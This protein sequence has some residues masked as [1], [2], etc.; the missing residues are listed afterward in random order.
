MNILKF[1]RNYYG[2]RPNE[3]GRLMLFFLTLFANSVF[4]NST[5]IVGSTLFLSHPDIKGKVQFVL[6][7]FLLPVLYLQ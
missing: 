5:N 2:I 1:A 3:F 4:I 7:W 6:P